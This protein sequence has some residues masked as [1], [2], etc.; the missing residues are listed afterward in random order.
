MKMGRWEMENGKWE[1]SL[2]SARDDGRWEPAR[3]GG[4]DD[5]INQNKRKKDKGVK[6]KVQRNKG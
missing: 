4:M 6:D 3:R 1:M 2:V 5:R